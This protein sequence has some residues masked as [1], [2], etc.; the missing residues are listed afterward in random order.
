MKTQG[1]VSSLLLLALAVSGSAAEPASGLLQKGIFAEETEGDLKTAIQIYEQIVE[2]TDQNR[3]LAGQALYRLG[4]CQL[5]LGDNEHAATTWNKLL[6]EYTEQESLVALA[7]KQM[8]PSHRTERRPQ[9]KQLPLPSGWGFSVSRDGRYLSY[10]PELSCDLAVYEW[11]TGKTRTVAT[12]KKGEPSACEEA[13]ISPQSDRI[14]YT[15][16]GPD[17]RYRLFVSAIEA[18]APRERLRGGTNES[19]DIMDWRPDGRRLLISR[20]T[21]NGGD[22][23]LVDVD[24]G[25]S[26]ILRRKSKRL[27]W[28]RF[29]PDGRYLAYRTATAEGSGGG[30]VLEISTQQDRE[31]PLKQVKNLVGWMPGGQGLLFTSNRSGETAVWGIEVR[32]GEFK[33]DARLIRANLGSVWPYRVT[34]DGRFFFSQGTKSLN[35]YTAVVDLETGKVLK[36]N[37]LISEENYGHNTVPTWS[38]DGKWI[39]YNIERTP[40]TYVLLEPATGERRAFS[41]EG[42][43]TSPVWR[44]AW[45]PRQ[46][47]L[48]LWARDVDGNTG[49][50]T[51][52]FDAGELKPHLLRWHYETNLFNFPQWLEAGKTLVYYRRSLVS[53]DQRNLAKDRLIQREFLTGVEQ[54]FYVPNGDLNFMFPFALS[55]DRKQLALIMAADGQG[56]RLMLLTVAD[57]SLRELLRTER[58]RGIQSADWSRDGRRIVYVDESDSVERDNAIWSVEIASGRRLKLELDQPGLRWISVHPDGNTIAFQAG[59]HGK[60]ELWV[61]EDFLLQPADSK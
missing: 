15:V 24:D 41:L 31:L 4:L 36:K 33:G 5:K 48:L 40:R 30:Y 57:G 51:F 17:A 32:L 16:W 39:G 50:F 2:Q 18:P 23:A 20:W 14:A 46:D 26:E 59:T 25:R 13:L 47:G 61:M 22:W 35:A 38:P 9:L 27:S 28:A 12:F 8:P 21:E 1:L 58:E 60:E 45:L 10:H 11:P 34:D 43:L 29:S 44:P 55:P 49:F 42:K 7:R 52:Q 54:D 37:S 3:A 53:R 19:I 6:N 56:Q